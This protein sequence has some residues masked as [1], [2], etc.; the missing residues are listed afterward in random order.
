MK[1]YNPTEPGAANAGRYAFK[2]PPEPEPEDEAITA[3][4]A[5]GE[6]GW[7]GLIHG[8][9]HALSDPTRTRLLLIL[10]RH[11]LSVGEL[12]ETLALP[13]STV[14]RHLRVLLEGEWVAS[15]AEGTSR[16]YRMGPLAAGAAR[17]WAA[18]RPALETSPDAEQ[19]EGRALRAIELRRTELEQVFVGMTGVWDAERQKLF[20]PDIELR[21]LPALLDPG[22]VVA[23]LGCGTGIVAEALAPHVARVIGVDASPFQLKEARR[24]LRHAFNVE[25]REAQLESLPLEGGSV[26][27]VVIMLVLQ[28]VPEPLQALSEAGRILKPG[29]RLLLLEMAAHGR[30]E[31]RLRL[32]HVWQGFARGQVLDWLGRAGFADVRFHEVP[33]GKGAEGPPLFSAVAVKASAN[34]GD[35][36]ERRAG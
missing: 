8:W 4:L 6:S 22:W 20:G 1:K 2:R 16:Y 3:A 24:R 5:R 7:S 29:G 35:P 28:Y 25:L 13:Q 33:A 19:D 31:Y 18:V 34:R 30:E 12:C 15:R 17:L 32:G 23:D 14:S 21:A 11:E 27:A 26:D 10:E 36:E 9:F